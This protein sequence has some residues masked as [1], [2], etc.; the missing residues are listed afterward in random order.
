MYDKQLASQ[1]AH[2]TVTEGDIPCQQL[3]EVCENGHLICQECHNTLWKGPDYQ[4]KCPLCKMQLYDSDSARSRKIKVFS[5]EEAVFFGADSDSAAVRMIERDRIEAGK[6]ERER[7]ARE[8][9]EKKRLAA[10]EV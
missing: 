5:H 6:K 8:K 4:K 9:R 2:A 7:L 1:K 10:L 3:S